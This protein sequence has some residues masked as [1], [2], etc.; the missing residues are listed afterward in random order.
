MKFSRLTIRA[1]ITGGSLLIAILIS[2]VAGIVIFT[3]VQRIVSDGQNRVLENIEAPYIIALDGRGA[4]EVDRPGAGQ[5]VAVIAG[6]GSLK[7]NTLPEALSAQRDEL[8]AGPDGTRTISAG[9]ETYLVRVTS[10][11]TSTGVWTI[12]TASTGDSDETVLNQVAFLLIAS[13]AGINIAF[14]ARRCG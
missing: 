10:V 9:S 7:I 4:D 1:R 5:L 13:I 3:Q 12:I 8:V 11:D 2:I 14:G 6:D